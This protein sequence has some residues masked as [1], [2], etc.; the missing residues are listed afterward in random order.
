MANLDES[1]RR[2]LFWGLMRAQ[3]TSVVVI[4]A[5]AAVI[6]GSTI[7]LAALWGGTISLIAYAWGGFQVWLHPG[8]RAAK[9][10][11]IMLVLFWLTF[12]EV[13]QMRES[14]TAMVLFLAFMSAQIA[15]WVQVARLDARLGTERYGQED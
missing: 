1:A 15:G 7:G 5:L 2:T 13:P 4:A 12:A 11:A 9:R 14:M 10:M 6:A 8:N 3:T